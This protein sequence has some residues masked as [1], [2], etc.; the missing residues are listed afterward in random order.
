MTGGATVRFTNDASINSD[1]SE[2][3]DLELDVGIASV[4]FNED[5][6]AG[7]DIL[8]ITVVDISGGNEGSGSVQAVADYGK[9]GLKI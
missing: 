1:T 3:N 4:F 5:I 8:Q 7:S 9:Q 2:G 6:G